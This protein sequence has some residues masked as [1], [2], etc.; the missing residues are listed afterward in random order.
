[1]EWNEIKSIRD[2]LTYY[3]ERMGDEAGSQPPGI[4]ADPE[5]LSVHLSDLGILTRLHQDEPELFGRLLFLDARAVYGHWLVLMPVDRP[6]PGREIIEYLSRQYYTAADR[7][8]VDAMSRLDEQC[9]SIYRK[10]S[11]RNGVY[12]E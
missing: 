6:H 1:M 9:H 4:Q 10:V 7:E 5:T 8:L 2:A 12:S 3:S 11:E